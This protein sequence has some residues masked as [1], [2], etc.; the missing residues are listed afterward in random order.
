M[1]AL[2]LMAAGTSACGQKGPLTLPV[3]ALAATT[4]TSVQSTAPAAA[5][6]TAPSAALA[7]SPA[8]ASAASATSVK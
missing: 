6:P 1:L 7:A 2:W 8:P 3:K 5:P 4:S